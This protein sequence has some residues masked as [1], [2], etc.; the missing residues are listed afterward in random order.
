MRLR[1]ARFRR[2]NRFYL[3]RKTCVSY[4][5]TPRRT[6]PLQAEGFVPVIKIIKDE[7]YL[8]IF[9]EFFKFSW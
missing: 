1:K 8:L 6:I 2:V 4:F 5:E 9:F 7:F 3:V